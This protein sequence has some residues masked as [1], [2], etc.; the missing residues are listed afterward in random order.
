MTMT[1]GNLAIRDH[2][3]MGKTIYLFEYVR[4]GIVRYIGEASYLG[5]HTEQRPDIKRTLRD[6]I[7]FELSIDILG[8]SPIA[9]NLAIKFPES[10]QRLWTMPINELKNLA[11]QSAQDNVSSA[12]KRATAFQRSE[13]IRVYV[14]RRAN[15]KCE[16]CDNEAPFFTK[17]NRHYLEPHHIFRLSNGGPDNPNS[18]A[19]LCPNCHRE[20]HYGKR[21]DALNQRLIKKL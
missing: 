7:I 14:L 18:V 12:E 4:R 19:A 15:G 11:T 20:A 2:Q 6:A 5:H 9:E 21:A 13:S 8:S 16:S 10:P 3:E 17:Q 1:K